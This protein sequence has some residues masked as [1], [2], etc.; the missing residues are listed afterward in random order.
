MSRPTSSVQR[1]QAPPP[2]YR[3]PSDSRIRTRRSGW[4]FAVPAGRALTG[5]ACAQISPRAPTARASIR[6]PTS[7]SV[8]RAAITSRAVLFDPSRGSTTPRDVTLQVV[9]ARKGKH[10]TPPHTIRFV[11]PGETKT[12]TA[13]CPGRRHLFGGGFQ[14][15]F[16][17]SQGGTHVTESRAISSKTWQVTGTAFGQFGA[18]LVA[19]AYCRRSK[20]PLV[21]EVSASTTVGI[22]AVRDGNHSAVP[23]RAAGLRRLQQ[24]SERSRSFS[25]MARSTS[26][27]PGPRR[28]STTSG[29]RPPSPPTATAARSSHAGRSRRLIPSRFARPTG[30]RSGCAC[31]R[32]GRRAAGPPSSAR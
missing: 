22:R 2:S 11:A 20:R 9:C 16:F 6:T 19:I 15:A 31:G 5:V 14:R 29:R 12:I 25:P 27:G 10:V 30:R 17:N 24:H 8:S 26:T 3:R 32:R 7:G 23:E 4:L 18:E 13:T 1:R 28:R 21:N